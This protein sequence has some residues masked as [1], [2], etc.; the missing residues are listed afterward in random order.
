MAIGIGY[1]CAWAAH[2]FVERNRPVTLGHPLW[3]LRSDFQMLL[4]A[5]GG[6]LQAELWMAGIDVAARRQGT[7]DYCGAAREEH[8]HDQ[9]QL[10]R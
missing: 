2:A 1:G 9:E 5:A 6:R 4:L 8:G 7:S 10:T 3:S